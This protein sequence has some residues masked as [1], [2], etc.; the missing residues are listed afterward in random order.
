MAKAKAAVT[1]VQWYNPVFYTEQARK[2]GGGYRVD[3]KGNPEYT[4]TVDKTV[5]T[6]EVCIGQKIGPERVQALI[7]NDVQVTII[8][9]K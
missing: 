3:E 7:D 5:N 1:L 2:T 6:L 9:H 4:Y 8:D